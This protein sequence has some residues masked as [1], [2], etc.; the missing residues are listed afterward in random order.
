MDPM[1]LAGTRIDRF[2]HMTDHTRRLQDARVLE[3]TMQ[4]IGFALVVSESGFN[5]SPYRNDN[6]HLVRMIWRRQ[7]RKTENA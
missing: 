5:L 3:Q 4:R 7:V 6:P 2:V 1:I